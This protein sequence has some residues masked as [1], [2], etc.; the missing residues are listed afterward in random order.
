M[1]SLFLGNTSLKIFWRF[2]RQFVTPEMEKIEKIYPSDQNWNI[3]KNQ[4][5]PITNISDIFSNSSRWKGVKISPTLL[6]G[7][8]TPPIILEKKRFRSIT[9]FL[10]LKIYLV[11]WRPFYFPFQHTGI[12]SQQRRIRNPRKRLQFN[13]RLRRNSRFG[14]SRK[15]LPGTNPHLRRNGLPRRK[16]LLGP[17]TIARTRGE[18]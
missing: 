12:L 13:I 9:L 3:L 17:E 4:F 10:T 16:S 14:I 7:P 2:S 8:K 18:K 5:Y 1:C 6:P 11:F 15:R